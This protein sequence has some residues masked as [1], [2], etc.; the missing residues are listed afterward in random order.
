MI[1]ILILG[2]LIL[3]CAAFIVLPHILD[4]L[5]DA[6]DEWREVFARIRRRAKR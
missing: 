3:G 1:I 6:Y 5:V 2:F 4:D